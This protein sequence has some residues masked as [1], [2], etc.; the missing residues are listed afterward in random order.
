MTQRDLRYIDME[1]IEEDIA[2]GK[3]SEDNG[4]PVEDV[5][6][7]TILDLLQISESEGMEEDE[8]DRVLQRVADYRA[9]NKR[10]RFRLHTND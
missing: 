7:E 4:E 2:A 3:V 1:K 6:Y 5:L 10:A 9:Q 8:V